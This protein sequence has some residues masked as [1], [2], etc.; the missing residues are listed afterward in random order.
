VNRFQHACYLNAK[1]LLRASKILFGK[2]IYG[3]SSAL[4]TLAIEEC[5][6]GFLFMIHNPDKEDWKYVR[7]QIKSHKNKLEVAAK[8]AYLMGLKHEGFFTEKKSVKSLQDF[9]NK[10]SKLFSDGNKKF[11]QLAVES[12]LIN[13]LQPL[14]EKGMYV[15]IDDKK[16]ITPK[17]VKRKEAELAIRQAER[18]VKY[19]PKTHGRKVDRSQQIDPTN[20]LR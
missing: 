19:F 18:V 7:E 10:V 12:Y 4:A 17:S 14:K 16:I 2:R 3:H 9:E 15:D 13:L 8:D 1:S 20:M 6:K 5:G 11:Q